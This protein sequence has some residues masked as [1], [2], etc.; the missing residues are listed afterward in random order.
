MTDFNTH[1]DHYSA[2]EI[3]PCQVQEQI[4]NT[5]VNVP[6]T[7]RFYLAKAMKY[8]MRCGSKGGEHW[9]KDMQKGFNCI[10]K[11]LTGEW[12]RK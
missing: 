11:A 12:L 3:E 1:D 4:I 9:Q 10:H 5:L 8:F 7:Q 2:Q 6:L